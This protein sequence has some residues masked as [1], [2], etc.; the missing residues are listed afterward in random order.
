M[1][2]VKLSNVGIVGFAAAAGAW[3]MNLAG[4]ASV[5]SE[6]DGNKSLLGRLFGVFF[7]VTLL[8]GGC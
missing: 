7:N 2:C 6:Q 8:L 4:F 1:F 3:M 5:D